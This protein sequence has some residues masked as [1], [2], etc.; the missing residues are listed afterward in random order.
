MKYLITR[1]DDFGS[2]KA[3]NAVILQAI[4]EGDYIRNISC[5][6]GAP[7][8]QEGAEELERLRKKNSFCIGLHAVLNSEWENVHFRSIL[9]AEEI[10][11]LV[12]ENGIFAA[13]PM[14]FNQK[15]PDV[16]EA[17]R[18][19]SAQ[20][21]RLIALKVTVEYVDTHML[22]DAAVPGLMDALSD[23]AKK[24]GLVD[25]RNYYTF[26]SR[27]Q[28]S[29]TGN[30]SVEEDLIKY[31][32]WYECM[33][34]EKQYINILH[35]AKYSEETKLFYNHTLRGDVVARSRNAEQLVLNSKKLEKLCYELGIRPIKYTE[36]VPQGDTTINAMNNF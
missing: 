30:S 33:E 13:H 20:L 24:K 28:P 10:P 25:Q 18:E 21:D 16:E 1:A 14:M 34:E 11:S 35:P 3:A 8:M 6:A 4:K 26:P 7:A 27:H 12:D 19:I 23:F 36:A 15:M 31:R 29:L 5:M 9:R 17:V 2:A 22:P 32:T